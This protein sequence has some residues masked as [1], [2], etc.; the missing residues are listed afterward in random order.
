MVIESMGAETIGKMVKV[1]AAV[2][3]RSAREHEES[4]GPCDQV[5]LGLADIYIF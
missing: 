4:D 5:F 3:A 2:W 1:L